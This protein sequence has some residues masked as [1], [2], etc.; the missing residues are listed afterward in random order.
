MMSSSDTQ[1]PTYSKGR[2]AVVSVMAGASEPP[3]QSMESYTN[4]TTSGVVLVTQPKSVRRDG[5]NRGKPL[6]VRSRKNQSSGELKSTGYFK[7]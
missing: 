2:K 3:F 4:K 1:R 7:S 6:H 5:G